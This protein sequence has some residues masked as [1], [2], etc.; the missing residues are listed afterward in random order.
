MPYKGGAPALQDVLSGQIPAMF[1]VVSTSLPHARAGKLK[2]LAVAA[3]KR[4]PLVP[5]V[6]TIAESG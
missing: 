5:D 4:S 6:P 1:S 2:I 3:L